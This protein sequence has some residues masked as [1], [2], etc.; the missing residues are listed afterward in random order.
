M[1]ISAV[2]PIMTI[3]RLPQ[4]QFG[5]SGHVINLPQDISSFASTLPRHPQ[6]LDVIIVR[7]EGSI[8]QVLSDS[9]AK[10]HGQC[11]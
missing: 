2:L 10:V 3:Y 4:G 8:Q 6:H 1:L 11:T 5:Y 7:R 9:L